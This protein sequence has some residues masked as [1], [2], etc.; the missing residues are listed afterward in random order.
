M[1]RP[2]GVT[3]LSVYH[4]VIGAILLVCICAILALLAAAAFDG[5]TDAMALSI[6]F[7][8]VTV[9]LF[10]ALAAHVVAGWALLT[11]KEWGRWLALALAALS[12][13]GFPV[14]TAIGG[15]AIWYLLQPEVTE[16]FATGIPAEEAN[17]ASTL[18]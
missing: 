13:P 1:K 7:I 15:L 5:S 10:I 2:D 18:D 14:G 11:M 6:I 4:F 12:L 9:L 3:V 17:V 8:V 16:A